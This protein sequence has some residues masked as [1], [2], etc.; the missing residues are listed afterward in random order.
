MFTEAGVPVEK[1]VMADEKIS[2]ILVPEDMSGTSAETTTETVHEFLRFRQASQRINKIIFEA[3]GFD[4]KITDSRDVIDA[5]NIWYSIENEMIEFMG[6]VSYMSNEIS[7]ELVK[8][9]KEQ[10]DNPL[11]TDPLMTVFLYKSI[12]S[13]MIDVVS[14]SSEWYRD[15]FNLLEKYN[16]QF[17]LDVKRVSLLHNIYIYSE[18]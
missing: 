16:P 3:N 14:Q 15:A 13:Q 18:L 1:L 9:L 17:K 6:F 5:S 8:I 2:R 10:K 7:Q 4:T 12:F 11:N